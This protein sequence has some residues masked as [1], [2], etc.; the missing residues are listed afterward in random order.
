MEKRD[1]LNE[2]LAKAD[3]LINSKYILAD[4]KIIGL[5]K[6]VASSETLIALFKTCLTD[7]DYEEAKKTYLIKVSEDRHYI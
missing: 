3:E 5:L 4:V 1:E 7:Y 2:F 6:T